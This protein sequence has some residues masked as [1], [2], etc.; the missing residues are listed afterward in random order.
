MA[1][2]SGTIWGSIRGSG[3]KQ[4]RIG[5][6]YSVSDTA[7]TRTVTISIWLWTRY[8]CED[9][10]NTFKYGW[11]STPGTTIGSKSIDTPSNSSWNTSNQVLIASYSKQYARGASNT[12]GNASA[13]YSNIEYAGGSGSVSVSF[14]IPALAKY[15]V[16]YN[17][18]GGSGAPGAQTKWYGKNITLST[19]KPSRT[20]YVFQGWATSSTGGVAYGSGAT[21]SGNANLT[22]YAVWK[23]N[24]YTVSYNANG[25]SGAP[26]NQTKTYDVNLTLSGT[27]PTRTNYNFKGWSTSSGGDVVYA[28]G[29][30]YTSNASITLYAVWELAYTIPRITNFSVDRCDSGGTSTESGTYAKVTFSWATDKA[31]TSIKIEYKQETVSTWTAVTV[32][33][34]GTSG[35]VSKI[36]GGSLLTDYSYNIKVTVTDSLDSNDS[37]K[38]VGA[39]SYTWDALAGGRGF[40]FGKPASLVDTL[41]IG[42]KTRF[43]GGIDHIPILSGT[44]LNNITTTGYYICLTNAIAGTLVNCPTGYAFVMEVLAHAGLHQ[45]LTIYRNYDVHTYIRNYYSN[46]WGSWQIV[47]NTE[48]IESDTDLNSVL[49]PGVYY[50]AGSNPNRPTPVSTNS[51]TL[52]VMPSGIAGQ[53]MQR[54]TRCNKE[55]PEIYTRYRYEN[56]FGSWNINSR[57]GRRILWSGASYMNGSQAATLNDSIA[58]QEHGIVLIFSYYYNGTAKNEQQTSFFIPK[59]FV[60]RHNGTG[61]S[62]NLSTHWY[63]G[64]KYLYIRYEEI[65]GNDINE[66]VKT[67][68]GVTY[69]NNMFVLRYVVGV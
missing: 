31:V 68:D 38:T 24:T 10:S 34:S 53:I 63:N 56:A 14:T 61:L 32:S 67:I 35:S 66:Q 9:S 27:K 25:G 20:G 57:P 62:F 60:Y 28:A 64:L 11:S 22:L 30:T 26:G 42:F 52:E 17:A 55:H 37:T 48:M 29:G 6:Y 8:R 40:A 7:T 5:I 51:F 43:T 41:D 58:N 69:K 50:S 36:I 12:T 21:Y 59:E 47:M 39:M 2:P 15:T 4:G 49:I 45:R 18:N 46:V 19:A 65:L 13:S 33:A 44:D 3:A 16:S 1:S 54:V 23:A